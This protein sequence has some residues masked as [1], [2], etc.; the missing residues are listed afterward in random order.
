MVSIKGLYLVFFIKNNNY[1]SIY[2]SIVDECKFD[3]LNFK[4]RCWY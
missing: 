4:V 1:G 2:V 3:K